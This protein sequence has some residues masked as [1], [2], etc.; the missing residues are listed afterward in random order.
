MAKF[1]I[2][3]NTSGD[4]GHYPSM[5]NFRY[6]NEVEG[7]YMRGTTKGILVKGSEFIRLGGCDKVFVPD[8]QYTWGRFEV[9][10]N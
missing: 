8:R 6:G 4:A 1:V 9:V 2:T 5:E 3:E 7:E 10:E